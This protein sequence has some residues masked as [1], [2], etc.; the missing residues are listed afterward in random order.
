MESKE[1]KKSVGVP[2]QGQR[3]VR[4]R[5]STTGSRAFISRQHHR[6]PSWVAQTEHPRI[7]VRAQ[8]QGVH[9][10]GL[11]G[12]IGSSAGTRYRHDLA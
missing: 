3:E 4:L 5:E 9:V 8:L 2:P 11:P 10:H 12:P 1:K 7:V 6:F